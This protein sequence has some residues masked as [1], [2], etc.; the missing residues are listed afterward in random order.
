MKRHGPVALD[1]GFSHPE[2]VATAKWVQTCAR[3]GEGNLRRAGLDR[4]GFSRM[5]GAVLY[6]FGAQGH[7]RSGE[8]KRSKGGQ[9]LVAGSG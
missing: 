9:I 8:I 5:I 2:F 3:N 1:G 7:P 4:R 6:G